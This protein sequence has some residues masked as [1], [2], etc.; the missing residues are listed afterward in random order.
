MHL[1]VCWLACIIHVV[2]CVLKTG[3]PYARLRVN[4]HSDVISAL[5]AILALDR[6][7]VQQFFI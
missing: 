4:P 7:N 5:T 2:C 3:Y 6:V 1:R